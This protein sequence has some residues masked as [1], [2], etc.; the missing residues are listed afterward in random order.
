MSNWHSRF[1]RLDECW[2]CHQKIDG[3]SAA[4]GRSGDRLRYVP[5][6]QDIRTSGLTLAHPVCFAQEHGVEILVILVH[7]HDYQVAEKFGP[8]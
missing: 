8:G 3:E 6:V 7:E 1:V 5:F 2:I 4:I